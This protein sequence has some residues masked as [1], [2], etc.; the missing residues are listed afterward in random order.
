MRELAVASVAARLAAEALGDCDEDMEFGTMTMLRNDLTA[1][2]R[3]ASRHSYRHNIY[4]SFVTIV[5]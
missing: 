3:Y 1:K 2:L 4:A 5:I